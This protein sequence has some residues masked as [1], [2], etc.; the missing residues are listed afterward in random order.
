MTQAGN[1]LHGMMPG[2]TG[3]ALASPRQVRPDGISG[4]DTSGLNVLDK[5]VYQLC[6]D[7][8]NRRREGD[9]C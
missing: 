6:V 8:G 5:L 3:L 2:Q 9:N 7:E 4:P 1:I